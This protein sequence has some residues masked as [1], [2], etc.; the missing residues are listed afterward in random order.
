MT[1]YAKGDRVR[2]TIEGVVKAD[3]YGGLMIGAETGSARYVLNRRPSLEKIEVL[4]K[5]WDPNQPVGTVRKVIGDHPFRESKVI[6]TGWT[7]QGIH[8]WVDLQSGNFYNDK[9]IS[10]KVTEVSSL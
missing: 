3:R 8:Q 2:V 9:L 1:E 6:K 5:A 4:E 7:L 10:Q